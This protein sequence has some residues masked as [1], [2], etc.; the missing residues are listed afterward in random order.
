MYLSTTEKTKIELKELTIRFLTFNYFA[1]RRIIKREF[2]PE[3]NEH[4][5]DLGCGTGILA[6]LFSKDQYV[7]IDLDK[8]LI[9]FAKGKYP[10]Y[11]F[12]QA[13]SSKLR[14]SSKSFDK[15]I[16]IGVI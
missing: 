13:D 8:K 5:L 3:K 6:P 15:I 16:I 10:Q 2:L 9:S 4:I 12:L 1:I 7:G 11:Q 14:F